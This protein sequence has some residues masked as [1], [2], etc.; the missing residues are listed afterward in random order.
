MV[1]LDN[2]GRQLL[3]RK[4]TGIICRGRFRGQLGFQLFEDRFKGKTFAL[5]SLAEGA[6]TL[7]PEIDAE[8][9]E[10]TGAAGAFR[11]QLAYGA[12]PERG[13]SR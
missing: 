2:I 5:A 11:Y 6:T 3:Q 8:T 7:T 12:F 10:H 13:S 9:L 1:S 4:C